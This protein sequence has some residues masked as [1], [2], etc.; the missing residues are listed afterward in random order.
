MVCY[1]RSL[2]KP[3][4]TESLRVPATVFSIDPMPTVARP[5]PRSSLIAY[6]RFRRRLIDRVVRHR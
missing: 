1:G 5:S 2:I 6:R 4:A 3:I